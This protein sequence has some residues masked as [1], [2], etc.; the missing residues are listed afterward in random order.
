M[1]DGD[2]LATVDLGSNSFRLEMARLDHGQLVR[3]DYYKEPVRLGAGLDEHKNLTDAAIA[4]SVECLERFAERLSGLKPTA[5]RAVATQSLR[6]ARNPNAFLVPAQAA[7]GHP[8]EVISGQEEARLIYLGAAA[9]LPEEANRRIVVD[10]GGGSTELIVGLNQHAE[11]TESLRIGCVSHTLKFFPD[12]VITEKAMEKAVTA[13]V[14]RFEEVAESFGAH[15]WQSA[16]GS[17]GTAEAIAELCSQLGEPPEHITRAGMKKIAD[18][19]MTLPPQD[20]PFENLRAQR[21]QV[22]AGGLAVMMGLFV[23]LN[24][25]D[26]RPCYSA[27]RQGVMVDLL[28]RLT[29]HDISA[30][31]RYNSITRLARRWLVDGAQAVRVQRTA[32]AL[33]AQLEHDDGRMRDSLSW[34]ALTHEVGM[35]VSHSGYQKHSDYLIRHADIAGF[36]FTE[37]ALIAD[38]VGMHRGGLKKWQDT[39]AQTELSNA[40]LCLRLA[41]L[42]CHARTD[43]EPPAITLRQRA[44]Y[45]DWQVDATW[46]A[47]FPMSAYLLDEEAAAWLKLRS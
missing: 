40:A 26:M 31:V 1:K 32:L 3:L 44:G 6:S 17:S 45:V 22:L 21:T 7:L 19:M 12:G 18:I 34:A 28:D 23:A 5:V 10:I 16:Y 13:A 2:I 25:T 8:I 11:R 29:D 24:I 36:S 47:A 43:I 42:L 9:D 39:L 30:D 14:A 41:V 27:L 15:Q 35:T 33:Y 46:R 4:R 37:Q 20:W 38:L